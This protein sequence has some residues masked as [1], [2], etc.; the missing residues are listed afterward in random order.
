L[1][2]LRPEDLCYVI[3]DGTSS[4][5]SLSSSHSPNFA[6]Q[7]TADVSHGRHQATAEPIDLTDGTV[8]GDDEIREMIVGGG[9]TQMYQ[10]SHSQLIDPL[11]SYLK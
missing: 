3:A 4:T 11:V 10:S 1:L 8:Q 6:Q 9:D 2:R 5:P 7:V